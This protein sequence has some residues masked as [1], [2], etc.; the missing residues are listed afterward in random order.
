MYEA[1]YGLKI[2]PFSILPDPDFLYWASPH[3][4][5]F[6]MLQYGIMN[7]AGFTV[8][9]GEVGS[10]K[11]TLLRQL[12]R[13]LPDDV[14]VGLLSNTQGDRGDLLRW[15]LMSLGQDF[16]GDS[17][18]G[19]Y[20]RFQSYLDQQEAI[21]R[22]TVLIIDE[23]QNLGAAALEELRMLSNLNGD[24]DERL[25]IILVGQ[26]ELKTLLSRPDLV[27]F[28]QRVSSDFHL[29]RLSAD[30][31]AGYIDH[32]LAVAGAERILFSDEA[33]AA[34]ANSSKGIPRLINIL[35]DTSLMYGFAQEA[36]GI[37][38][39]IVQK[40]LSDKRQYGAVQMGVP[41]TTRP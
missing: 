38:L 22:R 11:T 36:E 17:Y 39:P 37:T 33:C 6:A 8:I 14:V 20:K 12:L 24:K 10:G 13:G 25:Q 9:T 16:E 32:R 18:V 2:K 15:L 34:I 29:T 1:F 7:R 31:V 30:D 41:E 23:A 35:C 4:L 27:Q 40:V 5:A 3:T 26:P 28:A 19:L 21:G